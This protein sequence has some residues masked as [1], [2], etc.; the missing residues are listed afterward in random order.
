[1]AE[2]SRPGIQSTDAPFTVWAGRMVFNALLLSASLFMAGYL[3]TELPFGYTLGP[4]Y[5]PNAVAPYGLTILA[6]IVASGLVKVGTQLAGVEMNAHKEQL[7]ALV[8]ATVASLLSIVVLV[9]DYSQLQLVYFLIFSVVLTLVFAVWPSILPLP[10]PYRTLFDSARD[11]WQRRRLIGLWVRY[12]IEAQYIDSFLGS[13]W[14]VLEPLSM[15]L[16]YTLAFSEFLGIRSPRGGVPFV[17]F[18]LSGVVIWLLFARSVTSGTVLILNNRGLLS[19]VVLPMDIL[20]FTHLGEAIVD[21]V[22]TSL[23][24]VALN[25]FAGIWPNQLYVFML[26]ILLIHLLF[27]VGLMFFVSSAAVFVR[28]LAP[29]L[30]AIL[31]MM[32]YLTPVLYPAER[33]SGVLKLIILLNPMALIIENYRNIILYAEMPSLQALLYVFILA[34]AMFYAGYRFFKSNEQKLVELL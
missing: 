30:N 1:L 33:V 29:L 22:I 26:P 24:M 9:P 17:S 16:I 21:F 28:D 8:L 11:I 18:F 31:R 5:R 14:I 13:L 7:W 4:S 12:G 6:L 2:L 34:A 19:Q 10:Y 25:A 23:I 32:F 3:R 27:T 15:A 20:V